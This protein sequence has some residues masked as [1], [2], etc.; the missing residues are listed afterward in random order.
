M[1]WESFEWLIG[2]S[3]PE[4]E[5]KAEDTWCFLARVVGKGG[6]G[7]WGGTFELE[8]VRN[9]AGGDTMEDTMQKH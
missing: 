8:K 4:K 6:A 5:E 9:I 3:V 2:T 7:G 1:F